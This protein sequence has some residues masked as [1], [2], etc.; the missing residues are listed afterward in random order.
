MSD[1]IERMADGTPLPQQSE[2]TSPCVSIC[3]IEPT[4]GYCW[5]CG[6]TIEEIG[7]WSMY[8][9]ERRLTVMRDLPDRMATLPEREKRVTKRRERQRQRTRTI[10]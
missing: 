6:R 3:Q 1:H 5:G 2:S 10:E 4:T 8:P 9:V 7:G